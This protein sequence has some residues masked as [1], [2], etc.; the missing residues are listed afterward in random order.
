VLVVAVA[1]VV[2]VLVVAVAVL[3]VAVLAVAVLVVA[4]LVDVVAVEVLVVAVEVLVVA[5]LV[6]AVLVDVVAVDEVVPVVVEVVSAVVLVAVTVA[7]GPLDDMPMLPPHPMMRPAPRTES[8]PTAILTRFI[9]TTDRMLAFY[10]FGPSTRRTSPRGRRRK[11]GAGVHLEPTIKGH[12]LPRWEPSYWMLGTCAV[13]S[14]G[15]L[16][17]SSRRTRAPRDW[18]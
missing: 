16:T 5:V 2:A 4:V 8:P 3:A 18:W 14:G 6:V 15:W 17:K 10:L 9:P 11:C 12:N 13:P 1:V 7:C